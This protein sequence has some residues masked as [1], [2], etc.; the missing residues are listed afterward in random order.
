MACL[1]VGEPE[2]HKLA[3]EDRAADAMYSLGILYSTGDG[4]PLDYVQAHMWFNLASMM[5]NGDAR[6]WRGQLAAEMSQLDIADAQKQ[7]RAW[8]AEGKATEQE[9]VAA[10]VA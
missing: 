9:E 8:I 5:G 10:E 2:L 1:E 4:V 6:E 7:A 3:R